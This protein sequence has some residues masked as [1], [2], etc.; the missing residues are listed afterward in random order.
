[1]VEGECGCFVNSHSG[2]ARDGGPH[3]E[4]GETIERLTGAV[5]VS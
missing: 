4:Q 5:G 1:M 2:T 3:S